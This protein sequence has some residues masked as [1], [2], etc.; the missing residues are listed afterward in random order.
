MGTGPE[1]TALLQ[2]TR[3]RTL[4]V[5]ADLTEDQLI[6]PRFPIVNPILWEIGHVAW[7]QEFWV[8]R[9]LR[10]ASPIY[11]NADALWDSARVA[12]PTRWELPLPSRKETERFLQDVLDRSLSHLAGREVTER[13]DYFYRLVTFHED[14]HHEAFTYTRQTLGYPEPALPGKSKHSGFQ[15]SP[16][17]AHSGDVEIPGGS[18]QLGS[19]PDL[20]FVFDNEKWA[21]PVRVPSFAIAKTAITSAQFLAFVEDG[22][23]CRRQWWSD[24]GWQWRSR[25]KAEHP[26]Y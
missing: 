20:G 1:L 14:M 10:G 17:G 6:V 12:H 21:H 8:L 26:V 9:H 11:P 13:E 3:T 18:F 22:G 5:V 4:G 15:P 2:D 25:E 19:T 7:F 23:Y 24:D 16:G